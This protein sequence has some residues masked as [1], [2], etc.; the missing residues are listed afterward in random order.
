M[1]KFTDRITRIV[2]LPPFLRT[3]AWGS[4]RD[5]LEPSSFS[6]GSSRNLRCFG[7][8]YSHSPLLLG[9][10]PLIGR[11][12]PDGTLR[13]RE[14]PLDF[15]SSPIPM[16]RFS[17]SSTTA[18]CESLPGDSGRSP[19]E[20]GVKA[21]SNYTRSVDRLTLLYRRG[22]KCRQTW[23]VKDGTFADPAPRWIYRL[24]EAQTL[25]HGNP[26]GAGDDP[27]G[28]MAKVYRAAS[29]LSLA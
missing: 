11:R 16:E 29:L 28:G 25:V 3:I 6:A 18:G 8:R 20:S 13:R 1:D 12:A 9:K 7:T 2:L 4:S 24:A 23:R 26:I 5:C 15:L 22:R 17:F 21:L 10:G 27:V 14:T 19:E